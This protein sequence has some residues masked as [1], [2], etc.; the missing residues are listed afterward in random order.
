MSVRFLPAG[1]LALLVEFEAQISTE[2]SL[3]VQALEF[4]VA[5]KRL[6][7]VVETV[8]AFRSLLVY[9]DPRI[10]GYEALCAAITGLLPRATSAVLPHPRHVE[11]PCCYEDPELGSDLAAVAAKLGL[12][13]AELVALHSGAEYLVHFIG[14]A[15]GQ[16][17][18]TGMPE[19][20][21]IP[22]L[23]TPR[24]STPA[25]SVG[26]GGT[27]CCIYSV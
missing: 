4:L 25:G 13:S 21:T 23:E 10:V 12:A 1:D 20:L 8:P 2:V 14:F 24:T 16:P 5:E 18:M 3:R 26:I 11:L 17:Y 7:G 22:R 15:P 6:P 9:Y 27:Q 19:R